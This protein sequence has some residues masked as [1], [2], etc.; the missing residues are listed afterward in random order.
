M[1][2]Q[3]VETNWIESN[4]GHLSAALAE[5]RSKLER[6]ARRVRGLSERGESEFKAEQDGIEVSQITRTDSALESLCSKFGLSSF[7][8]DILLLSAGVELDSSIAR[9]LAQADPASP[10]L[11]FGLALSA[12]DDAHWSALSPSRPLRRWRLVEL[13]TGSALTTT[14]LRIDERILHYLTGIQHLDERLLGFVEPVEESSDLPP[15]HRAIA[16]EL[17]AAWSEFNG[18]S[19]LPVAQLCGGE[20]L[21]KESIVAFVCRALQMS[22]YKMNAHAIPTGPGELEGLIRLWEREAA[23]ES[24]ALI[25]DCEALDSN[26]SPRLAAVKQIIERA[27]SPLAIACRERLITIRRP[28]LLLDIRKPTAVEQLD[29]WQRELG[30]VGAELNGQVE[31]IVSQF[32]LSAHVIRSASREAKNRIS[33]AAIPEADARCDGPRKILWEVCRSQARVRLNELAQRIE[34][35]AKR[36][37]LVLPQ[38]QHQVLQDIVA[39]VRQRAKVY[40]AWGFAAKNSRGLGITAL[41]TGASGTGKTMAAEVIANELELDLYRIDLSQIVS[42][43][44]GETEKNLRQVFDAA[45]DGGAILLFDEADAI[46]GKRTEVKDS[47]DRYANIEV[48]YLLQRMEA[49]R[50]L[51]IL[52]TNLKDALDT[53]FL[54]RIRFVVQFPFPDSAGRA[55]IW[56]RIFP[57]ALPTEGLSVA[58]LARIN[59]TGGSIYN[60]ALYAAFL[61]AEENQSVGMAHLLRAARAEYA[62]LERTLSESEVG[63]WI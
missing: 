16:K 1:S 60:I 40:E 17:E 7:E 58:K 6:Y 19:R 57:S 51:A 8:C 59:V 56:R 4:R 32:N 44:I 31:T 9:L 48:S 38:T 14:S 24:C 62:K 20:L 2:K 35:V 5:A 47:H 43:Y 30:P 52:T 54:R 50:G 34:P 12:L 36:D 11:T 13:G 22:L 37:D 25:I 63:D 3:E 49:Y 18:E 26:D 45:E 15:S 29:L 42:K 23:L 55:E 28:G 61:A 46:F 10:Y 41:F 39:H 53:A 21:G 33:V 27:N